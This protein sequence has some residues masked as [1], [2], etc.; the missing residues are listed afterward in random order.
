MTSPPQ[1][2]R[3]LLLVKQFGFLLI[4]VFKEI[5]IITY[6]AMFRVGGLSQQLKYKCYININVGKSVCIQSLLT[7]VL[8]SVVCMD[9]SEY[10]NHLHVVL[11]CQIFPE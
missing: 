9:Y 11:G 8:K 3:L 10:A 6:R 5:L 4:E 7:Q 1:L 2:H